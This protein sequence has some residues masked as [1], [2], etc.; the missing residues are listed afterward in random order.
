MNLYNELN[1]IFPYLLSIRKLE[2]YVSVDV[3]FPIS[4]KLP[5]KYVD[6]KM[7]VEQKTDKPDIRCFSFAVSFEEE[8]LMKLFFN[9]KNIIRYNLEREEKER[10][11]EEKIKEL[12]QFFDKSDLTSLKNLEFQIKKLTTDDGDEDK[13][14]FLV[15]HGEIEGQS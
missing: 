2:A 1:D 3:E 9:L 10:L 8:N 14:D 11:F 7:I 12:K 6:E 4:W 5:K 13:N 15:E